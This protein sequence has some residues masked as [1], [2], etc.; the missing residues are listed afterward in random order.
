MKAGIIAFNKQLLVDVK[1]L[2]DDDEF[3]DFSEL[4]IFFISIMYRI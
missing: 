2:D 3:E 1:N 4:V